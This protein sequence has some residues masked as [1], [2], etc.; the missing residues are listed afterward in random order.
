MTDL[1]RP[2]AGVSVGGSQA[3]RDRVAGIVGRL[4]AARRVVVAGWVA[5]LAVAALGAGGLTGQ[6]SGGGWYVAGSQSVRVSRRLRRAFRLGAKH[7]HPRHPGRPADRGVSGFARRAAAA[8][9]YVAGLDW[10]S[11]T[12]ADGWATNDGQQRARR[13]RRWPN[14]G[15]DTR[16]R[17]LR[18]G[19][20]RE[21][22]HPSDIDTD[23]AGQDSLVSLLGPAP[24]SARSTCRPSTV[25]ACGAA[26]PAA[27]AWHHAVDFTAVGWLLHQGCSSLLRPWCGRWG[28][29][30]RRPLRRAVVFARTPRRC[31][32]WA[33]WS[34]FAVFDLPLPRA[35]RGWP[36]RARHSPA[37]CA[38][39]GTR[40]RPRA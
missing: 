1:T 30:R 39:Q 22:G 23:F 31:S 20:R 14:D 26:R 36:A 28:C 6:L 3:G 16:A 35:G 38:L 7:D 17:A 18:R 11:V 10:L 13:R 25:A 37:P 21:C 19:R 32:G 33:S 5:L 9:T 24:L 2:S 34:R 8:Y 12:S 4:V 15:H 40:R 29:S 27:A